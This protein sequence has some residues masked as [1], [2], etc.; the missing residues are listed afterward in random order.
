YDIQSRRIFSELG[1]ELKEIEDWNCCGATSAGKVDDFLA[2]AMPAR[3]IGIAEAAGYREI[4]IPCSACY[5]RTLVAQQRLEG[6]AR[7]KAEINGAF[8]KKMN[9]GLKISSILEVLLGRIAAGALEPKL[10]RK[11]RRLKPVCYYGC[12]QTRF[13]FTVPVPD[14]VENPQGMETVLGALGVKAIDWS[15]KTFCCG[16]SAAVNDPETSLNL[17]GKIMKDALLRGA[18]CFVATCPMCQLNLDAHQDAFCRRSGIEERL[19]VFFITEVVGAAMGISPEALQVDR[20]FI[21]GTTLLKE[22]EGDER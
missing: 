22:L 13:P 6:D 19:P 16:A 12:M 10:K 20:H 8:A 18:N 5:S 7:L 15:H 1:V 2:V 4:V 3:N 11:F 14:D 17:M 21:D 9:G